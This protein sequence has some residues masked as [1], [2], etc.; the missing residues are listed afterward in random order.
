MPNRAIAFRDE[1]ISDAVKRYPE[2]QGAAN[3]LEA[4]RRKAE[5]IVHPTD[6]RQFMTNVQDKLLARLRAGEIISA[7]TSTPP[8]ARQERERYTR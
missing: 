4:A 2:L 8:E 6:Q 7:P 1:P 3:A 5:A